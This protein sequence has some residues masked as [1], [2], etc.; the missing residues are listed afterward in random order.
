L[1]TRDPEVGRAGARALAILLDA[2]LPG[3]PSRS[4]KTA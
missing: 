2:A 4:R 3:A 1:F